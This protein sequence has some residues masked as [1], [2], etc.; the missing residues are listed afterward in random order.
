MAGIKEKIL[1]AAGKI[2]KT[3]SP[4]AQNIN[5]VND[6]SQ[7]VNQNVSS[8]FRTAA[9]EGAVLLKN[10]GILPLKFNSRVSLF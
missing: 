2:Y 4:T 10:N 5:E 7:S 8:L 3:I 6:D 1:C 9:A